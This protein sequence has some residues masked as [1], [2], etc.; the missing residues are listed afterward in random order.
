[1]LLHD[2]SEQFGSL[3]DEFLL[4]FK[5]PFLVEEGKLAFTDDEDS[6]DRHVFYLGV[7]E[8]N[9]RLVV[10]RSRKV[11]VTIP[12][13]NV[14][15]KHLAIRPPPSPRQPWTL[16]DLGSTN[17]TYLNGKSIQRGQPAPIKNED[18]IGFGPV[19][20]F[21]FLEPPTFMQ[22]LRR[23]AKKTG[24]IDAVSFEVET[25]P[26]MPAV[27]LPDVSSS[28]GG[29]HGAR[30]RVVCEPFDPIPLEV[31]A[32][33]V[34]G[35][36]S[37]HAQLVLPHHQVSRR[38]A[39]IERRDD[40]V[41]VRDLH[42]ANGSFVGETKLSGQFTPFLA[43]KTLKVGDFAVQVEG[44]PEDSNRFGST[45]TLPAQPRSTG[46][47]GKLGKLSLENLLLSLEESHKSG[48]VEITSEEATGRITFRAGS[49]CEAW[50][51]DGRE[52]KAAVIY[53]L[54]H[55]KE[56]TYRIDPSPEAAGDERR[57]RESFS[58][59]ALETFLSE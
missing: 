16:E 1:M 30:L 9:S 44:Y 38:H 42:S 27:A 17:G 41:Y 23:R 12:N 56:G 7:V 3:G 52:H 28:A 32:R 59:L 49:P 37:V 18:V 31:G 51:D 47:V 55:V 58:E 22:Y 35:R 45:V 34:I 19:V 36:S 50:A 11:E 40:G 21:L 39:E 25:S 4:H 13:T 54:Q 46:F 20:S 2:F 43:G 6:G 57:I 33:I 14:S 5:H 10:G 53:L 29:L 26:G 8:E 48:V 24:L 15:S